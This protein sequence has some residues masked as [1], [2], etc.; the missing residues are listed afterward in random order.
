VK[1]SGMSDRMKRYQLHKSA[2][3]PLEL[4]QILR[5]FPASTRNTDGTFN[6][7]YLNEEMVRLWEAGY[8]PE[9][10]SDRFVKRSSKWLI[11]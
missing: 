5:L 4:K 7:S 8:R 11:R 10:L 6:K 3:L 1:L 9:P 2:D